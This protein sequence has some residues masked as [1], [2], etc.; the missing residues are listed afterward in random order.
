MIRLVRPRGDVCLVY[1][2]RVWLLVREKRFGFA[3][4]RRGKAQAGDENCTVVEYCSRRPSV[5]NCTSVPGSSRPR[6]TTVTQGWTTSVRKVSY[7]PTVIF[8][9]N[10]LSNTVSMQKKH[11]QE[12]CFNTWLILIKR[13]ILLSEVIKYLKSK[14]NISF[15][16]LYVSTNSVLLA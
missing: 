6:R 15:Y 9:V 3:V 5:Q 2:R 14:M 13:C 7:I 16:V 11:N 1:F 8:G 10:F 12:K 4:L